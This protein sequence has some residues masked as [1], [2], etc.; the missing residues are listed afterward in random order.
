MF[1]EY[2]PEQRA[3]SDAALQSLLAELKTKKALREEITVSE[4]KTECIWERPTRLPEL[5]YADAV[6]K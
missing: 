4:S 3:A 1:E 2:T 5:E 6:Y